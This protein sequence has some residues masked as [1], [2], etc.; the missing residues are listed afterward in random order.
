M[1]DFT[2][3]ITNP[4]RAA[5]WR[6]IL[7]TTTAPVVSPT[8]QRAQL[9]GRPRAWV[10]LLDLAALTPEQTIRLTQ[11]LA[12]K[13][14]LDDALVTQLLADEGCPILADDCT[15]TIHHLQ[16]WI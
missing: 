10:Y 7:G 6:D 16:R 1:G 5:E 8:L 3:T 4:E 2:V 13:F 15:L 12:R 14:G 9:P 11:H